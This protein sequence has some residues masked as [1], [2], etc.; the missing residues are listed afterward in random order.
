[1]IVRRRANDRDLWVVEIEDAGARHFLTE[2][3]RPR[4]A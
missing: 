1:M 4:P 3:V 2:P